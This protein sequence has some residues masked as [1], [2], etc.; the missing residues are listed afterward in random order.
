[1]NDLGL[2]NEIERWLADDPDH[3]GLHSLSEAQ[4]R[5]IVAALRR[6]PEFM[7]CEAQ[8]GPEPMMTVSI[9]TLD[10][11][12]RDCEHGSRIWKECDA[13]L[14]EY[15][16]SAAEASVPEDR[17]PRPGRWPRGEG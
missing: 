11:I 3:M 16:L 17:K 6:G 9:A 4:W 13:L 7:P 14:R 5:R 1:V 10:R 12:M 15:R 2:A 8:P